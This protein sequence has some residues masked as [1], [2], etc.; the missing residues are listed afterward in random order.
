MSPNPDESG[1]SA[2]E[3]ESRSAEPGLLLRRTLASGRLHSSFLLAGGGETP[4][5][6][7]LDFVRGVVCTGEGERPCGDCRDCMLSRAQNAR[8]AA[9]DDGDAG[10]QPAEIVID[11][12]GKRGPLYRHVGDHPDLYWI[13]RGEDGTRVRITQ[14]RAL[15]NALRLASTEGGWRAAVIADAEWL[16]VEAQNAL[17]HL[18]EE[19]PN[20]TTLVL[21]TSN[22]AGLLATIRSRCQKVIFNQAARPALRGDGADPETAAVAERLD[23]I[24]RQNTPELL[25]W[26]EEYRGARAI[27]AARVMDLLSVG[28]EW[29]RQRVVDHVSTASVE[30]E[31]DAFRTLASC[32]KE[33]AQR[34]ANPQMIAERALLAVR[35][36]VAEGGPTA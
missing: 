28:S 34:N 15:Q 19:P 26:A 22:P 14:V 31:L 35:A 32:R 18:L 27:A 3:S 8:R 11:G 36:A 10:E 1:P 21:V 16:N 6:A 9:G 23:G 25:D 2:P 33:L 30:R 7:A 5:E 12:T 4:R 17:L 24:D 29:L 20:R 13:D